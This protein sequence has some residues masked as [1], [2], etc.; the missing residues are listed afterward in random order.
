[1]AASCR[2]AE[3]TERRAATAP[4]ITPA[5]QLATT[6]TE[7]SNRQRRSSRGCGLVEKIGCRYWY[8][9]RTY[10]CVNGS[11]VQ[12]SRRRQEWRFVRHRMSGRCCTWLTGAHEPMLQ[13]TA[14]ACVLFAP[15]AA[16]ALSRIP[17]LGDYLAGGGRFP[18]L[19]LAC[20]RAALLDATLDSLLQVRPQDTT[21]SM[22]IH[23]RL[24]W[25]QSSNITKCSS[26]AALKRR[27]QRSRHR[28]QHPL[29]A[30]CNSPTIARA[31]AE[32]TRITNFCM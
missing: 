16:A 19:L 27:V 8:T 3:S 23:T 24:I 5:A 26:P 11:C 25:E 13:L 31:V 12:M 4:T 20:E 30:H 22:L 32:T 28:H 18:I 15:A 6:T 9:Y 14:H 29:C 10:S 7:R 2:C 21:N 17:L 1:V